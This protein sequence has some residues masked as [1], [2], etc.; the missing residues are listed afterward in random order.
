MELPQVVG[1][2]RPVA[3]PRE[4]EAGLHGEVVVAKGGPPEGEHVPGGR[5]SGRPRRGVVEDRAVP[6]LADAQHHVLAVLD[7]D[8]L[9]VDLEPAVA[10][11]RQVAG[12]VLRV[13]LLDEEVLGVR[14]GV[15]EAPGDPAVVPQHHE[16]HPGE[17]R[18]DDVAARPGEVGEVPDR[19]HGEAEVRVVREER[20]S[21]RAPRSRDRPAIRAG[22]TARG[23]ERQPRRRG[24]RAGRGWGDAG[25]RRPAIRS[26]GGVDTRI[27]RRPLARRRGRRRAGELDASRPVPSVGRVE[28]E[29]PLRGEE[30]RHPKPH[31]V[32]RPLA[33]EVERHHLRPDHGVGRRPRLGLEPD[34]E[35]LGGKR[36]VPRLEPRVDP[37]DV[38][39]DPAP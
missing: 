23:R 3:R 35:E 33:T 34:D 10:V 30:L 2:A 1:E 36:S 15:G 5:G 38:G 22:K 9:A 26:G 25:K 28:V 4:P 37:V 14:P 39:A 19:R 13:E 31:E 12:G 11:Q 8:D 27:G 21:G 32:A 29:D 6:G 7:L 16:R 18:P 24:E 20:L 17:G